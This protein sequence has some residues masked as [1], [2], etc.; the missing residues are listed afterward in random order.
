MKK[1]PIVVVVRALPSHDVLFNM[2]CVLGFLLQIFLTLDI[3][4]FSLYFLLVPPGK[5]LEHIKVVPGVLNM[6]RLD[7]I[8][9]TSGQ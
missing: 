4:Y 5:D 1:G 8:T 3:L 9:R 6:L 2:L 7:N